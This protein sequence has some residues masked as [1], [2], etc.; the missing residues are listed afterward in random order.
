MSTARPLALSGTGAFAVL[1]RDHAE[2]FALLNE[3][4]GGSGTP[5]RDPRA[6]KA[7]AEKLVIAESRHEVLEERFFW[8]LVRERVPGGAELAD[9]AL[10]QEADAKDA[11]HE[12]NHIQAK[13]EVF[14]SATHDLMSKIREHISFEE[15]QVWP[16]LRLALSDEE[17]RALG[18]QME[19]ARPRAPTRPHP[20]TPPDPRVLRIAA[21]IVGPLD[22]ARDLAVGRGHGV[23]GRG[24]LRAGAVV[25]A[26]GAPLA[27]LAYRVLRSLLGAAAGRTGASPVAMASAAAHLGTRPLDGDGDAGEPAECEP[28]E[29]TR[30]ARERAEG[31][32]PALAT[33]ARRAAGRALGEAAGSAR[34]ATLRRVVT[35]A[36]RTAARATGHR[37]SGA[38]GH[39]ASGASP[40]RCAADADGDTGADDTTDAASE[41]R[42]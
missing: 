34:R 21:P 11:L 15:N 2:I 39:Y 1:A 7:L 24:R 18:E 3:L 40:T 26:L 10:W 29:E 4:T 27:L 37:A 16:K 6:R 36:A 33:V 30:R 12:F 23:Q 32:A 17:V 9:A 42:S 38:T 19:A 5:V 35:D 41:R 31:A 25:V 13:N 14:T 20:R 8:P 28:D 22:R